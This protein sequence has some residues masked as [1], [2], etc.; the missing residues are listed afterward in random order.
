MSAGTDDPLSAQHWVQ[1]AGS[2]QL[3]VGIHLATGT[4]ALYVVV[5]LKFVA[6]RSWMCLTFA[7][8]YLT[9][10]GKTETLA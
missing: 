8:Y 9:Q 1:L 7:T 3:V 2:G 5:G 10:T 4:V 6:I